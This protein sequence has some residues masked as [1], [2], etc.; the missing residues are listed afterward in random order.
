MHSARVAKVGTLDVVEVD[1]VVK[2]D[3][4]VVEAIAAD[5]WA[6][7]GRPAVADRAGV[8]PAATGAPLIHPV[9][10]RTAANTDTTIIAAS[11]IALAGRDRRPMITT[12]PPPTPLTRISSPEENNPGLVS[13]DHLRYRPIEPVGP[14]R[15]ASA[16]QPRPSLRR[17]FEDPPPLLETGGTPRGGTDG[18][19][20]L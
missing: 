19:R 3:V 14:A 11:A 13:I 2:V 6:A 15:A 7:P 1:D 16:S 8:G 18:W 5:G 17:P 4:G 9:A 20:T 12:A 10:K